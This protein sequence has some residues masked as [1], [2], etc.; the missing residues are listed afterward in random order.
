MDI[1]KIVAEMPKAKNP[2]IDSETHTG[3]LVAERSQWG[4]DRGVKDQCQVL[5]EMGWRKVPSVEQIL[6]RLTKTS[7]GGSLNDAKE[8]HRWLLEGDSA[9]T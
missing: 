6:Y 4:F 3:K 5:A 7:S 9:G 2:Y 1:D 8:L